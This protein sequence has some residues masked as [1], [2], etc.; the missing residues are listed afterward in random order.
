M[1]LSSSMCRAAKSDQFCRCSMHARMTS[2]FACSLKSL[3][4]RTPTASK[5]RRRARCDG[6]RR[7]GRP[8][9]RATSAPL[10]GRARSFAQL[11]GRRQV[12]CPPAKWRSRRA[13]GC[14]PLQHRRRARRLRLT[15]MWRTTLRRRRPCPP[16]LRRTST[17]CK[18]ASGADPV[19][20]VALPSRAVLAVCRGDHRWLQY[21]SCRQA[22]RGPGRVL[23]T[24]GNLA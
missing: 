23:V 18:C 16:A 12:R 14:P 8:R 13:C 7:S 17:Q 20:T 2:C 24:G 1:R 10:G 6:R 9:G 19:P 3:P 11:K 15:S 4:R 5:M 22:T 21:C